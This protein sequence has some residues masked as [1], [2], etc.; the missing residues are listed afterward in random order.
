MNKHYIVL[1]KG[2]V[3]S[4]LVRAFK[5][6]NDSNK[7][8]ISF[9]IFSKEELDYTIPRNI[10]SLLEKYQNKEV[11]LINCAGF[12]GH[13]NVD[14]CELSLNQQMAYKLNVQLPLDLAL[15]CKY[16]SKSKANLLHISSGCIYNGYDNIYKE[17]D[18]PNFGIYQ[19]DSSFY[20]KTKHLAEMQLQQIQFGSILRVRMIFGFENNNRNFLSKIKK[21]STLIAQENSMTCVSDL[22]N[23]IISFINKD[24]DRIHDIYNVVNEG[25][26]SLKVI[27]GLFNRY[28]NHRRE[29]SFCEEKD[30]NLRAKRSNCVLDT[31]KIQKL[32]LPLPSII[33][34]LDNCIQAM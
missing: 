30:L 22:C 4:N 8:Q 24:L 10:I 5:V 23:F 25:A 33:V 15:A 3:G 21:Y 19:R 32:G 11:T 12:T 16:H 14:A 6:Y 26:A 28:E 13:P 7:S 29:W 34:S 17:T 18:I 31:S 20:S 27:T 2:Y 9:E 1:G